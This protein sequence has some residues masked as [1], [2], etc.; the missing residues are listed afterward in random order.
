MF[1]KDHSFLYQKKTS[2]CYMSFEPNQ[3]KSAVLSYYRFQ[4]KSQYQSTK[5]ITFPYD[6]FPEIFTALPK[7]YV[8]CKKKKKALAQQQKNVYSRT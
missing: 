8:K 7:K 3:I 5:S 2:E 1:F 4:S 6:Y